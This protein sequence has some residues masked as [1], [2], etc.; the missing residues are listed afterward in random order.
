MVDLSTDLLHSLHQ[1]CFNGTTP[2]TKQQEVSHQPWLWEII[3][4][5]ATSV[6]CGYPSLQLEIVDCSMS[7]LGLRDYQIYWI[8]KPPLVEITEQ[9]AVI[10]SRTFASYQDSPTQPDQKY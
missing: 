9:N 7:L 6:A 8:K 1:D 5:Q 4:Q 2:D 3:L 10:N